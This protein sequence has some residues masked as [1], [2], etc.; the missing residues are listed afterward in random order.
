MNLDDG[1]VHFDGLD[2]DA[3]NL[4]ALQHLEDLIEHATFGPAVHAGIDGVPR[5]ETTG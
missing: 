3:H 4:L 2:L 1:G 5:A